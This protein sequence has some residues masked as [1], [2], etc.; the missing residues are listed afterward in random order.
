MQKYRWNRNPKEETMRSEKEELK[1]KLLREYEK[2][3][4]EALNERSEK[5][6]WEMED[7]VQE[8]KNAVGKELMEAK[9]S[10]KK[11]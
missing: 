9:L 10:F 4:D 11:K 8:I 5:T 2:R 6:L 7:E 1:K 3:L